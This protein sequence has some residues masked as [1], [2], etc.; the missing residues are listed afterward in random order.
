MQRSRLKDLSNSSSWMYA[1]DSEKGEFLARHS[2]HFSFFREQQVT[3]SLECQMHERIN[4]RDVGRHGETSPSSAGTRNVTEDTYNESDVRLTR[5]T[6][7]VTPE[8]ECIRGGKKKKKGRQW[9]RDR[10]IVME[11][12]QKYISSV[13]FQISNVV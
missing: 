8:R 10:I 11:F 9:T 5:F 2:G 12:G 4:D 13:K 6:F 7:L 3:K 1:H